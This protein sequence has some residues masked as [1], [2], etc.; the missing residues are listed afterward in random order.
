MLA[1]RLIGR[2]TVAAVPAGVA[3]AGVLIVGAGMVL[4]QRHAS[5][6]QRFNHPSY[7]PRSTTD[8]AALRRLNLSTLRNDDLVRYR[9]LLDSVNRDS[10]R[11][12]LTGVLL[13]RTELDREILRRSGGGGFMFIPPV[14]ATPAVGALL[15]AGRWALVTAAAFVVAKLGLR[16]GSI[17]SRQP[18]LGPD[19]YMPAWWPTGFMNPNG[20]NIASWEL[21]T[22]VQIPNNDCQIQTQIQQKD[23]AYFYGVQAI[24]VVEGNPTGFVGPCGN[25]V[26]GQFDLV[27]TPPGGQPSAISSTQP[28]QLVLSFA[29]LNVQVRPADPEISGVP[30]PEWVPSVAPRPDRRTIP[31]P[32]PSTA[33]QPE[34]EPARLPEPQSP[35]GG[36]PATRPAVAPPGTAPR[37]PPRFRPNRLAPPVQLPGGQE[38]QQDGK[39]GQPQQSSAPVKQTKPGSHVV[40][41]AVI[42]QQ[43]PRP[44]LTSIAKELGRLENKTANLL[45]TGPQSGGQGP[46]DLLGLVQQVV[47]ALAGLND[48]GTYTLGGSCERDEQGNPIPFEQTLQEWQ[49]GGSPFILQNLAQRLD[50]I[51][52]ML[53]AAQLLRQPSCK[54][55]S[56]MGQMVSVQFREIESGGGGG[57]G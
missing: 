51:A 17:N 29:A 50:A 24:T 38:I 11:L 37:N 46:G 22:R 55:P 48:S 20:Q 39:Q 28:S 6:R 31:Q 8:D 7:D 34:I 5:Y 3:A 35:P 56:P 13:D 18:Y 44:Q 47:Q 23:G 42:P 40:G 32:L 45:R 53:Q 54:N 27:G 16:W 49:W 43:G 12:P 36:T 15:Q 41:S 1:P 57:V 26:P 52:E 2:P 10:Y 4:L 14:V 21:R 19:A 30:Y 33:P 9:R 25:A